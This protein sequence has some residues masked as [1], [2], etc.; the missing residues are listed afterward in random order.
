MT[1]REE[2]IEEAEK[3]L[4]K[5]KQNDDLVLLSDNF[6]HGHPEIDPTD[7][8]REALANLIPLD[9]IHDRGREGFPEDAFEAADRIL[10]A[11]YRRSEVPEPQGE[12][13]DAQVEA[14]LKAAENAGP[15]TPIR[16]RLRVALRAA[17]GV[18]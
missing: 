2:L 7:D 8:E 14:A 15:L 12:P 3:A 17:G 4:T 10:A 6:P 9:L 1:T 18:R 16:E 5:P 11:G 13:T